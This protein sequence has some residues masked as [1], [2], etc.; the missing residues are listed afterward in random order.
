M[1]HEEIKEIK[2]EDSKEIQIKDC[3]IVINCFSNWNNNANI[4]NS[5]IYLN[6]IKN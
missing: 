5:L 3:S 4:I 1:K 6:H 2:P